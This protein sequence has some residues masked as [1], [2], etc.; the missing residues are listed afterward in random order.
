MKWQGQRAGRKTEPRDLGDPSGPLW[1]ARRGDRPLWARREGRFP[2][3]RP[4]LEQ[5]VPS[6]SYSLVLVLK[7]VGFWQAWADVGQGPATARHCGR[8]HGFPGSGDATREEGPRT[9]AGVLRG[10][11]F[12]ASVGDVPPSCQPLPSR[13][14]WTGRGKTARGRR[15]PRGPFSC[16]LTQRFFHG[17]PSPGRGA[18]RS[19]RRPRFRG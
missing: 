1:Q 4:D 5:A 11:A 3:G 12:G 19:P 18:G 17:R 10:E 8:S 6:L 9:F 2:G 13:A 7:Q 16:G 14:F 15:R